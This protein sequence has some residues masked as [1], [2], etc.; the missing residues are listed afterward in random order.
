MNILAN[1]KTTHHCR[2]RV[3]ALRLDRRQP[4]GGGGLD[5]QNSLPR[6]NSITLACTY[7]Y[8]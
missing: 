6:Y 8:C 3:L 4:R 1:Q 2:L 5:L 7:R